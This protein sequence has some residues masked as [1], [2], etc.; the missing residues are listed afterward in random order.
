VLRKILILFIVSCFCVQAPAIVAQANASQVTKE[1]KHAQKI[2]NLVFKSSVGPGNDIEV[3]LKDKTKVSGY[4]SEVTDDYFV[5]TDAKTGAKT[6]VEYGQVEKVRL[7]LLIQ[8]ALKRN[9][10]SPGRI[11]RNMAIG[12]GI[13]FTAV[14]LICLASRRCQE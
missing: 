10:R 4:L 12:I 9:F 5:V 14:A 11:I 2:K 7:W 13:T 3:K 8:N 1:A 6:T